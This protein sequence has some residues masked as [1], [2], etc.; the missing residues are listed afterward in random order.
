MWY[1]H[2]Y[3]KIQ[4]LTQK[5]GI[6]RI[7]KWNAEA[8]HSTPQWVDYLNISQNGFA[9]K[10]KCDVISKSDYYRFGFKLFKANGKLFGDESIQTKDNNFVIHIGKDF[11]LKELFIVNYINGIRQ[12]GSIPIN[13]KQSSKGYSVELLIDSQNLLHFY[14]NQTEV[15]TCIIDREAQEQ[16]YMLAW[17]DGNE[18]KIKV[19]H[20]EIEMNNA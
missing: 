3:K 1:S 6:I 10:I 12:G 13:V 2:I 8:N 7:S 16:I 5:K 20:I 19:K 14:I 18:F 17:S 15:F 9:K 11:I 4:N